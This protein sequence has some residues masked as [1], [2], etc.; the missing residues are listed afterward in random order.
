MRKKKKNEHC[1]TMTMPWA[2]M[3]CDPCCCPRIDLTMMM[4]L[5]FEYPSPSHASLTSNLNH[6][7]PNHVIFGCAIGE[8]KHELLEV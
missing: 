8:G 6:K 2:L 1:S 3:Y 5:S 7:I 4:I